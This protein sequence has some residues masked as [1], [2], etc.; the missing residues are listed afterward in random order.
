MTSMRFSGLSSSMPRRAMSVHS[1]APTRMS[2]ASSGLRSGFELSDAL[3]GGGA[4]G[5]R[6]SVSGSEKATMQNLNDRL[7]SYLSKVHELEAKNAKLEQQIREWYDKKTP[8]ARDYSHYQKTIDELRS[9]IGSAAQ[10]NGLLMLQLDNTKLAADDF[11]MKYE[12]ELVMCQ[13]VESD[14]LGLRKVMDDLTM[15][16]SDLE[17]Q[18]EGLREELVFMKKNHQEDM[19]AMRSNITSSSVNVEVDA[20]PQEDLNQVLEEVRSQYEGIVTKS[21]REMEAWYKVKFEEL[22]KKTSSEANELNHAQSEINDLRRVLQDLEIQLESEHSRKSALE[23]EVSEIEFR[24]SQM[25]SQLQGRV[26]GLEAEVSQLRADTEN[27]AMEFQRLLD[28]KTRLE[29]EIAEYRRLLCGEEE[30]TVKVAEVKKVEV[31]E[32]KVEEKRKPKISQRTYVVIEEIV[33]GKVVSRKEEV[34]SEDLD[35]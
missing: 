21:R 32:V 22:S 14:I 26:N 35:P 8:T 23:R 25:L 29:M 15:T 6:F 12:N 2:Y 18:V 27:Q 34:N 16:R 5:E 9:K 4:G 31:K 1:S 3:G 33:D 19:A 17:M 20:K 24:Y 30:Q 10:A 13:S 7:A 28:I 11:R